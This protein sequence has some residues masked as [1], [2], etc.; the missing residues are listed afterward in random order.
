MSVAYQFRLCRKTVIGGVCAYP[1]C[2]KR[3]EQYF[4][5]CRFCRVARIQTTTFLSDLVNKVLLLSCLL[6]YEVAVEIACMSE[7]PRN[8]VSGEVM[9]QCERF[10]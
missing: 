2:G 8:L 9:Y 5:Y 10:K 4:C 6:P 7:C 3:H 1:Y